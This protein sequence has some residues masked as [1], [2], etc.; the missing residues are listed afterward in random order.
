MLFDLRNQSK[1]SAFTST[2]AQIRLCHSHHMSQT[3][4][5]MFTVKCDPINVSIRHVVTYNQKVAH[6]VD[7]SFHWANHHHT[8]TAC[9]YIMTKSK[10]GL[11]S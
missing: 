1:L 2:T 5:V 10:I 11:Y 7:L 6:V 8:Q 9:C 3:L 4:K